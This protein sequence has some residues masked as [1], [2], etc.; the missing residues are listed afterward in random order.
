MVNQTLSFSFFWPKKLGED[1]WIHF[2]KHIFQRGGKKAGGVSIVW[3][4]DPERVVLP[5]LSVQVMM[6]KW[7]LEML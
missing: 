7:S 6:P 1:K 4:K 3:P 2:D 5:R